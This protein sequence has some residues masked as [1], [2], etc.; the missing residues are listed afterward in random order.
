MTLDERIK[1]LVIDY[2]EGRRP[3]DEVVIKIK[4]A[5]HKGVY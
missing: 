4:E 1:E 5:I 2:A 3:L